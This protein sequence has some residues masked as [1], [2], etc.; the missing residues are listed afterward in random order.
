MADEYTIHESTYRQNTDPVF[1][2]KQWSYQP[3]Q[4]NGNYTSRQLVFD[5]SG[6]YNSQRFINPQEMFIVFPVVSTLSAIGSGN[7][8]GLGSGPHLAGASGLTT[9]LSYCDNQGQVTDQFAMGYKSGYWHLINSMQI[10]IDGK[11]VIQ[12]IPNSNYHASFVANTTWSESDVKKMGPILGFKP[13]D[14]DSWRV[15]AGDTTTSYG[16]GAAGI[17]PFGN[18]CGFGICNNALTTQTPMYPGGSLG[19][20]GQ[21][22]PNPSFT[23]AYPGA[24]NLPVESASNNQPAN[25]ALLDRIKWVNYYNKSEYVSGLPK[26]SAN[27]EWSN[28]NKNMSAST[29]YGSVNLENFMTSEA[30]VCAVGN[31]ASLVN[32]TADADGTKAFRQLITTCIVRLKDV[33]NLFANLP[34]SRGLYVRLIINLNTGNCILPVQGSLAAP[35]GNIY[36][37]AGFPAYLN[38][39]S[40]QN[41]FIN[42]TCPIMLTPLQASAC[43]NASADAGGVFPAN[44]NLMIYPGV[45]ADIGTISRTA[46]VLSVAL[47]TPDP[48][49][50]SNG[51]TT[52][53]T[54]H[55][56]GQCRIYAPIIDMEPALTSKY[57]TEHKTKGV[58]YRD[59][60]AFSVPAS[61]AVS[62]SQQ[63]IQLA[64]GVV[65]AKRLIMMPFYNGASVAK[66][67]NII[68]EPSSPFDSA[69]AT[70]APMSD[71]S[72]F[73]VLISN[74]NVFQ[75]SI[76]YSFENFRMFIYVVFNLFIFM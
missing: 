36:P 59:I 73:Q 24:G 31:A 46:L 75:R 50:K 26:D 18:N 56:L 8:S 14:A 19:V 53:L 74:M 72:Q 11:D 45:A 41:N 43:T 64:N 7:S 42:Q 17:A 61:S 60:L 69:P 6:F 5:L 22:D 54:S 12:T 70:V 76:D 20:A 25:S 10:Q 68:F 34:L 52:T 2:S 47:V 40:Y 71:V 27:T 39:G 62:G 65:N 58:K 35:S 28:Y 38:S 15:V 66:N 44:S 32:A 67:V 9:A 48:I 33:C 30:I 4:N 49:H 57:L 16:M 21:Y 3:D 13:D 29:Q 55:P 51:L 37:L 63:S 23:G 1:T